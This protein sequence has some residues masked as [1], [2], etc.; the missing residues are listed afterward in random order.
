[1]H[2]IS[3]LKVNDTSLKINSHQN[4]YFQA[5]PSLL[6]ALI[7]LHRLKF[8]HWVVF[9]NKSTRLKHF[10]RITFG[11]CC[12]CPG[13]AVRRINVNSHA[14]NERLWI[15]LL[16]VIHTNEWAIFIYTG[17]HSYAVCVFCFHFLAYWGMQIVAT[18]AR[19][20]PVMYFMEKQ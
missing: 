1:M 8:C 5:H 9:R 18:L 19:S 17:A 12:I 3:N 2:S 10:G 20:L 13:P 15:E 7:L 11:Y 16:F 4:I 6:G 14:F